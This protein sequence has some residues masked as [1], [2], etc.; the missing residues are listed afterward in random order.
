ML[1]NSQ[2]SEQ[3]SLA[4]NQLISDFYF[5]LPKLETIIEKE[6]PTVA[7]DLPV[8]DVLEKINRHASKSNA[9]SYVLIT[10]ELEQLRGILTER[11]I[12]R[13]TATQQDL[14]AITVQEVMT[15]NVITLKK[16][17]LSD[18][19]DA[20]D[21]LNQHQISHLPIISDRNQIEGIISFNSICQAIHP[22]NLLKFRLVAEVMNSDVLHADVA[23]TVLELSQLMWANSQSYVVI[24]T[25]EDSTQQLL[26]LGIITERDIIQLQLQ[27]L[28]LSTI[29][30]ESVMRSP[31]VCLNHADSLLL[32]QQKMTQLRV[33]RL[34]VVGEQGELK[35]IVS[36]FNM[37]RAIDTE[38]LFH[39]ITTLH[40]QL[41]QKTQK[42]RQTNENLKQE[43]LQRQIVE[44]Q[45]K[46]EKELAQITLKSIGD[47]VITTNL[48]DEIEELNPVAEELTGWRFEEV[49]GRS[50]SKVI[51]VIDETTRNTIPTPLVRVLADEQP[52][53]SLI[54]S[55]LIARDGKEYAIRDSV[56][57]IRDPQG[58]IIGAVW[59]FHDVTESRR[60]TDRLSW[61]ASHDNLTGLYNRRKFTEK[62]AQAIMSAQ[63][64]STQHVLCY[65]DLDKF[66][67]VNDTCG[68]SAGDT[69]LR[70]ITE[71]LSRR[72]RSVDT[73]AR[74]G[75][76]EFGLLLYQCKLTEAI[77]VANILRQTIAD[78]H[79]TWEEHEF[80]IGISIGLVAIDSATSDLN[81]IMNVADMACYTAKAKGRNCLHIGSIFD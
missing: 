58:E 18:I 47:G 51:Q 14:T 8:I 39:V 19:N 57:P 74:L 15:S 36:Q 9:D 40:Q 48:A 67:I 76:D 12:L 79:F 11:D 29:K 56:S 69:L 23:T 55:V 26:P 43:I 16:P 46:Q 28:D 37:L 13:L 22:S 25:L 34:V 24:T 71:L 59:I 31:L 52:H 33:R 50:L 66:K 60:R 2:R 73:L 64:D 62:L 20:L 32:A 75:G 68:H 45:L 65:C 80:S 54:R 4:A 1:D 38:E 81:Q 77:S 3:D 44:Q 42:I 10:D 61:H 78:F 72:V 5:Q 53:S 7:P 30:V 21:L 63:K 49:K 6:L 35:G 70:Q 17:E 27:R 41:N